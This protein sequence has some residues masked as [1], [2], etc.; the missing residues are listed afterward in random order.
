MAGGWARSPSSIVREQPGRPVASA[1]RWARAPQPRA[2][3]QPQRRR[4]R[5][6]PG[7]THCRAPRRLRL[8]LELRSPA[9]PQPRAPRRART[10]TDS[11]ARLDTPIAA[12][13]SSPLSPGAE[14][15]A[16]PRAAGE[17]AAKDGRSRRRQPE[18][19]PR[20]RAPAEK[21][22][23]LRRAAGR[24]VQA[25]R[26][27]EAGRGGGRAPIGPPGTRGHVTI[28]RLQPGGWRLEESG[29]EIVGNSELHFPASAARSLRYVL[30][31]IDQGES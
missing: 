16:C 11:Q 23:R 19:R 17:P 31:T 14:G 7:S 28:T 4:G 29:A 20:A 22:F 21:L 10:S 15:L 5:S 6:E 8:G 3:Q 2:Q 24:E 1:P 18:R 27:G 12:A 25:R 13:C 9:A 26:S 30:G